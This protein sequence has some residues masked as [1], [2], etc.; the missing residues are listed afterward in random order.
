MTAGNKVGEVT[1]TSL[2]FYEEKKVEFTNF[3]FV[4]IDSDYLQELHKF[5]SEVFYSSDTDY[6]KKPHLGVLTTCNGRKYVIPLTSAK[7][8]HASWRDVT[9][10]N[11]RIYEEIDIRTAVTDR[12]D[13]IVD[14]TDY[15]K[16][17][18]KGIPEEEFKY[19]KKR[20]LSV[21]EIKKMFPVVEGVY[22]LAALSTPAT[23]P[24]EEQ[25]RNLMIKEY[26]FCKKY[27]DQIEKKAKKI[28]EKQMS[29]GVVAQ[30]HCNF[31]LLE[32]VSD[33]YNQ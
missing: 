3:R 16:L 13:I 5:D 8:K 28:Y 21:L 2:F 10:T 11:Y 33:T 20:I 27:D 14:E 1:L 9:S 19:H 22:H 32:S 24:A 25:R 29:T 4:F 15:N 6:S 26:F 23:D 31:K 18:D 30:Y 17:R 7:P 12:Y